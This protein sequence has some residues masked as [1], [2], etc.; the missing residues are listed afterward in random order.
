M[1]LLLYCVVCLENHQVIISHYFLV[2]AAC[3]I[4]WEDVSG[5]FDFFLFREGFLNALIA[6]LLWEGP[7]D[8]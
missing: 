1:P 6:F 5:I 3:A 4:N 2:L 7:H 8:S